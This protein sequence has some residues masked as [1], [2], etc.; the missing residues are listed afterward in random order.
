MQ[1]TV[2]AGLPRAAGASRLCGVATPDP[3]R[4][5]REAVPEGRCAQEMPIRLAGVP[6]QWTVDTGV[7]MAAATG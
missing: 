5:P 1:W 2:D 7:P 4:L 6:C 3:M